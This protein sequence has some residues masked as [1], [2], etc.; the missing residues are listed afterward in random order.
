MKKSGFFIVGM[1]VVLVFGLFL[2]S[3]ATTSSIG[4]TSDA[5]GL[6]ISKANVVIDS[7]E[8]IATYSVILGLVDSGYDEYAAAVKEAEAAGKKITSV[9]KWY[10]F[11]TETTAYAK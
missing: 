1:A 6:I 8:A 3:C 5:H 7:A 10:V 4:G 11:L 9:T 2:G